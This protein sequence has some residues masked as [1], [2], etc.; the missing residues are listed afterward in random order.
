MN[1]VEL[2]CKECNNYYK[3]ITASHLKKLRE[4]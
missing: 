1:E 4:I 2:K 3:Q